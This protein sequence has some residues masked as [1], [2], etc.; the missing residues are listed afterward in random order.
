[1]RKIIFLYFVFYG[2]VFGQNPKAKF[3][4]DTILLGKPVYLSLT[5]FH[6]GSTD[7]I[8]PDSTTNFQPFVFQN[9]EY[10]PTKTN[11]GISFDSV[12]YTLVTYKIDSIYKLSIP[13]TFI[14]SKRKLYSDTAKVKLK[15]LVKIGDIMNPKTK[16]STG[17][18]TVPLDFNYPKLLYLVLIFGFGL[19]LLWAVFGRLFHRIFRL[20]QFQQKHKKFV[21]SY[22][23]LSKNSDTIENVSIGLV[24]WKNH[25]EWL[26][27]KPLSTMTTSEITKNLNNPKLEEAL[28]EFDLAI[29]GGILSN[30]IP[31]AFNILF[32]FASKTY[33]EQR[34]KYKT[35]LKN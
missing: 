17:F 27:K 5:Y 2:V 20:W 12:V 9:S 6:N 33:K 7:L 29:Y 34:K 35:K 8:F 30:H 32:D 28:K 13:L 16:I 15:S 19:I 25:L 11:K 24:K 4:S 26:L 21:R 10:F 1:M 18:F 22:K 3:S 31:F 14:N 23:K